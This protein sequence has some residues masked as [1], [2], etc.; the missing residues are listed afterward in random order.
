MIAPD[1]RG[2]LAPA[3]LPVAGGP[4]RD[5]ADPSVATGVFAQ[6]APQG[7]NFSSK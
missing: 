3:G 5:A 6:P 2:A 4:I 7:A 1:P